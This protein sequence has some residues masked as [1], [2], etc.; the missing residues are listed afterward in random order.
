MKA[1]LAKWWDEKS[2]TV[3]YISGEDYTHGEVVVGHLFLFVLL[4]LSIVAN[5]IEPSI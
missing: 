4:L 3:S 1:K 2:M 5:W